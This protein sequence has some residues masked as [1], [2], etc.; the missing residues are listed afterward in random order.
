MKIRLHKQART[1]PAIR[2]EIRESNLSERALA[3]KY[4]ISRSTVRKWKQ[5]LSEEDNSNRPHT[6]HTALTPIEELVVVGLRQFLLLP[7]DDL[8]LVIRV[9]LQS[10][11]SRSALDRCL[12]RHALSKLSLLRHQDEPHQRK[13]TNPGVLSITSIDLSPLLKASQQRVL[14][15]AIDLASRWIYAE[16]RPAHTATTFLQN[17]LGQAPFPVA[18]VHTI[19]N[20][21][22][23]AN[24]PAPMQA[25][26]GDDSHPFALLCRQHSLIH[27]L[28]GAEPTNSAHENIEPLIGGPFPTKYRWSLSD[29]REMLTDFCSFF[30]AELPLKQLG[31]RSPLA[32]IRSRH[33]DQPTPAVEWSL[34]QHAHRSAEEEELFRLRHANRRLR[35]EQALLTRN[36]TALATL[37]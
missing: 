23:T 17:L 35:L 36:K 8:L 12:R 19:T 31:N 29:A 34:N 2:R 7:L 1:T 30:N 22:F 11:V 16:L 5:R 27:H 13:T 21:E 6:I 28:Y 18:A 37:E 26:T 33:N 32:I 4:S 24:I 20:L 3:E 9:F 10:P 25:N 14:Y 15:L